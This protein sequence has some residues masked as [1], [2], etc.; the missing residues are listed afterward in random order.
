MEDQDGGHFEKREIRGL[1]KMNRSIAVCPAEID[2][3]SYPNE[4][5]LRSAKQRARSGLIFLVANNLL[6]IV[7][8]KTNPADS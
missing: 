5:K 1:V 2:G 4:E 7:A 3:I 6:G 8:C